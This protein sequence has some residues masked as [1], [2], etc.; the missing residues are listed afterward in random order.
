VLGNQRQ[1]IGWRDDLP[2]GI[3]QAG[4]HKA[5]VAA[6]RPH[7]DV[8]HRL[9]VAGKFLREDP[10]PDAKDPPGSSHTV[11]SPDALSDVTSGEAVVL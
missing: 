1:T 8:P 4:H 9:C 6:E 2:Q 3:D 10:C 5:V 7:V 11:L